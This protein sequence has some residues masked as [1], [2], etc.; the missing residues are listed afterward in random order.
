MKDF[1]K[2]MKNV[3]GKFICFA[4]GIIVLSLMLVMSI[5]SYQTKWIETRREAILVSIELHRE[6][7]LVENE[8][9]AVETIRFNKNI[10]SF[11]EANR[12]FIWKLFVNDL[13]DD[14]DVI[15]ADSVK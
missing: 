5:T 3:V 7:D 12:T 4:T 15:D 1:I 14:L 9:L 8:A 11:Q 13:V 2:N 6:L 10:L